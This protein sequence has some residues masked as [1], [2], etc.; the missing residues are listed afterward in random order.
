MLELLFAFFAV[1]VS[2]FAQQ[3][4]QFP[5]AN[6]ALFEK[7]GDDRFLVPTPGKTWVSG[8]FGCVRSDGHQMHEGLDIKCLQRDRRGEPLDPV[9]ATADGVVAYVNN[10]PSFSNYGRYIVL[11]HRIGGM[12][13][14]S[15][16]A[17]LSEVEAGI[18]VGRAVRAGEKIAVMGR[19][20]NTGERISKERAHVHFELNLFYNDHFDAWFKKN[21]P[22]ERDDHGNYNGQNLVG[23]D[24][25]LLL[26]AEH[27]EGGR[28]NLLNWIQRRT[29]L[30]RVLVRKTGFSWVRRYPMLVKQGA[31]GPHEAV[32]GYEIAL[33]YNGLPFE[34][35]PRS[36]TQFK[37]PAR[38]QL[39][40]VNVAEYV[41][42]PCRSLVTR[43]G[44]R[45]ELANN[46]VRLLDMLT[47]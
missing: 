13:I 20:S 25:R 46:G 27:Q 41:K 31:P 10:H 45:W 4:F 18:R 32:A 17:H 16:Y 1:T 8:S 28:F 47:Y 24:P 34:L 7:D 36:A 5:T 9:M 26:L 11:Y 6:H 44:T 22:T 14:Y 21:Y 40:S 2:A 3:P 30:C 19:T 12:E 29:E 38:Y 43:R 39:V 37:G 15:L 23:I 33:D 42:N 35:I